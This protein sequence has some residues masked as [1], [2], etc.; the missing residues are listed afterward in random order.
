MTTRHPAND[1]HPARVIEQWSHEKLYLVRRYLDIFCTGMRLS[2][3]ALA[4][5]DF[6]AGPGLCIDR[7]TGEE[8]A[9]SPLL[10]V[11]RPEFRRI[12]LND[13]DPAVTSALQART[14]DQPR[15]RVTV[16]TLDCNLAVAPARRFL[17][18]TGRTLPMLG[19]AVI[20]P[21]AYQ[22]RF[23]SIAR[24]TQGVNLDL[25]VIVMTGFMR[26][27]LAEPSFEKVLDDFFGVPTW[28]TFVNQR[29]AGEKVTYRRLLD[30]YEQQLRQLGYLYVDDSQNMK[31]SRNST[32]YHMVF[33]SK[34][35]RGADFFKKI[36]RQT[37]NGQR[38]FILA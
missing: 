27:F 4:Y 24:L 23:E 1:G 8:T 38:S 2:W 13:V 9:G 33:A 19:L 37:Y 20:D 26:R 7:E 30:L 29:N 10:A 12:F 17:F 14:A 34:H 25:I 5:A 31:N 35:P 11:Q 18:P 36:S 16:S 22:M 3:D 6:L 21:T 32:I 15:E 28:R